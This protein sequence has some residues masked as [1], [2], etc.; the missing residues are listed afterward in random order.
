MKKSIWLHRNMPYLVLARKGLVIDA[1]GNAGYRRTISEHRGTN[2]LS[3]TLENNL[4]GD[5]LSIINRRDF[6]SLHPQ[7]NRQ[8][9]AVVDRVVDHP[10]ANAFSLGDRK[11]S[12]APAF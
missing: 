7:V 2:N 10:R 9:G 11:Q 4:A 3:L 6:D 1:T 8:D 5:V 12:L